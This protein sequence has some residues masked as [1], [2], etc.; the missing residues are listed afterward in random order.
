MQLNALVAMLVPTR[1]FWR[2]RVGAL[3]TS[4]PEIDRNRTLMSSCNYF[5]GTVSEILGGRMFSMRLVQIR[6]GTQMSLP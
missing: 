2:L 3:S 4:M 6:F 1:L 5:R